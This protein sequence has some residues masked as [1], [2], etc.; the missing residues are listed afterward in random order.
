LI[1]NLEKRFMTNLLSKL[2]IRMMTVNT[3]A[4]AYAL[5]RTSSNGELSW[6]KIDKGSVAAGCISDVGILSVKPAVNNTDAASPIALPND[7]KNPASIPGI[8]C[9]KETF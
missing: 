8:A 3:T 6:K 7:N 9:L 2:M 4:A 5:L 1:T